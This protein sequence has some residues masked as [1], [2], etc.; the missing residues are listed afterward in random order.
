MDPENFGGVDEILNQGWRVGA[1]VGVVRVEVFLGSRSQS[2]SR[3]IMLARVE[4]RSCSRK[5]M[6]NYDCQSFAEMEGFLY[7]EQ[8]TKV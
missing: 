7:H 8:I 3:K 2:R 5:I 6:L 4:S 1:G